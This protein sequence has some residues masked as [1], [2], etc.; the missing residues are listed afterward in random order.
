M[1][2]LALL[3]LLA[4]SPDPDAVARAGAKTALRLR[5]GAASW[6]VTHEAPSGARFL[7]SV[8]QD[9]A[10]R[11][12]ALAAEVAGE[13]VP[14][15]R[16]VERDGLWYVVDGA[17][18]G[19]YRPYEAPLSL[20][21]AYFYLARSS[22]M[23]MADR[24]GLEGWKHQETRAGIASYRAP[25]PEGVRRSLERMLDRPEAR[26]RVADLLEQGLLLRLELATGIVVES[27][28]S[29]RRLAVG[30]FR[31]LDK[32]DEAEFAVAGR[33]W[34]DLSADP[35]RGDLLEWVMIG[36][37]TMFRP[38]GPKGELDVRLLN[39]GSGELRRVPF[40][41]GNAL[42]GCFLRDRRKAV[43]SG[44]M[45]NGALGLFEVD[46]GTGEN[47]RLGGKAL[48]SGFA[49]GPAP[50]PD[51]KSLAVLHKGGA[52]GHLELRVALVDLASGE[53][54][55]VGEPLDGAFLS[56]LPDGKGLVLL[57]REAGG[58]G[59]V[60]RMDLDGRITPI[61]PGD[62]PVVLEGTRAILFQEGELWKTCDLAGKNAKLL[63]DGLRGH[64][65]PSPAPDGK[66]LLMMRFRPNQAPEPVVVVLPGQEIRAATKLPGLWGFPAWR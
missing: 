40:R 59:T 4:Q 51:G 62:S 49:L 6:T 33:A 23:V 21:T 1:I 57:R 29:E 18:T 27:G 31:L 61:V 47:R 34:T 64:G 46:L 22:V 19:K 43:V 3:G 8:L 55:H 60:S 25:V 5:D 39:L 2:A 36:H 52:E 7:V 20:S 11:R 53:G 30:E 24:E 26:A 54:R 37:N 66:R 16:I 44:L 12:I 58:A 45:D 10:R 17:Q 42:P 14:L 50:S 15:A 38:G 56:W 28:N 13:K 9:R 63:G 35:T 65:F 41:G 32:V 48:E